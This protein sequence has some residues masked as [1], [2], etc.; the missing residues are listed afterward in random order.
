M[1]ELRYEPVPDDVNDLCANIRME[2]FEKL[3]EANFICVFDTKKKTSDGRIIIARIKKMNDE[4]KYF[5]MEDIGVTYDYIIF[6]DKDVWEVLEDDDKTRVI[7]HELYHCEIDFEKKKPYGLRDHEIQTFY[8]EIEDNR[9]DP[10]WAE[11][12]S[13]VAESVHDKENN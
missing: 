3:F 12:I 4:L 9:E 10:Q 8:Q 7:T 1:D 2:R 11:R 6:I 5:T 13:V